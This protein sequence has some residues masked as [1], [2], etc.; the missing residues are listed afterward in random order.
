M[1]RAIALLFV[2]S[3]AY[4][5]GT[6]RPNLISARGVGMGG[7]FTAIADDPTAVYFNPAGLDDLE[8]QVMVG[9]ELVYGPRSFVPLNPDGTN[10]AAQSTSVV[11]PVP[12]IGT[13][14]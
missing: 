3:T 14:L 6:T 12:A 4:A 13:V 11:A 5:G 7:A 10:G 1:K 2:S 8:S 9:G